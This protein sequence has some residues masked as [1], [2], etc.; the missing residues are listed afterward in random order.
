MGRIAVVV[1]LAC[2][3]AH[4][5]KP[6]AALQAAVAAHQAG[7]LDV[8]ITL[9]REY[10]KSDPANVMALSN[11]GAALARQGR[12][13]EAVQ[14]YQA[15]LKRAPANVGLTLNLALAYYKLGNLTDAAKELSAVRALA[16]DNQ[17]AIVL[18]ADTWLQFGENKKVIELLT[19][20]QKQKPDDLGICYMLGTALVRDRR[21]DE[22]QRILE[23]IFRRGD[24]AEARL[25]IGTAKLNAADFTGALVEL[26]KAVELNPDLPSVNA[27]YGQAL[28]ET[29]DAAGAAKAFQKELA[30]N[31]NHFAS[32]L[33]TG[34]L[35]KQEQHYDEALK[36]LERALRVRPGDFGVR[37][38]QG[39]VYLAQG[40]VEDA[41]KMFEAI[42]KEAPQFTE[43]HVTLA[44]IYYRLKR[45]EDGDR[46]RAIVAKLNAEAQAR[47]QTPAASCGVAAGAAQAMRRAA[48]VLLLYAL[49][50]ATQGQPAPA[51]PAPIARVAAQAAQAREAGRLEEALGL[52]R[53]A[54]RQAPKWE[55]G[56]W[57]IGTI[58]YGRDQYAACRDAFRQ[59]T[60]LNSRLSFGLAFLGLCEFQTQ[61]FAPALRHLESAFSLGLPNGEQLTDVAIY[62][63]A[64]LHTRAGDFERALQ[65]CS[66]LAA[67]AEV[68]PNVIAVAGIAALRR[69]IFPH[70]LPEGDR[71]LAFQLG[72][73]LLAA[74]GRPAAETVR[75]FEE[76]VAQHPDTPNVH[77]TYSTVLLANES[78]KALVHLERELQ[79]DPEHLPALVSIAFEYLKRG[80][81]ARAR[82]YAE[83]AV[84]AASAEFRRAGLPGARAARGRRQRPRRRH[85][86]AGGRRQAGA[87]QPAGACVPGVGLLEGRQETGSRPR[88]GGV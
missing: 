21:E 31:P 72:N 78:A 17:Q 67:K 73:A 24:S 20:V 34:V 57:Q 14:S 83:R 49:A 23:P 46:E 47:Q 11:L 52:Y 54:L 8:A 30:L 27:Y 13:A 64:L 28:M 40:K 6:E 82:P 69:P 39:A 58:E 50:R 41:R 81:P 44:T 9:Y 61:E 62:H 75:R 4:G 32:N 26:A 18:L 10:L 1:L 74:A 42:V 79:I 16:P 84:K 77:Y 76:I 5:Q 2:L 7:N 70:Q 12:Y 60:A 19:P 65:F 45:K 33:N 36:Y 66:M 15:G 48:S 85:P 43:A 56:W 38:Q 37:Y 68:D 25:L 53:Q 51:P 86:G 22:G 55:E 88:E 63:L 35:L 87:R 3:A 80:E 59:F 29:G 71:E